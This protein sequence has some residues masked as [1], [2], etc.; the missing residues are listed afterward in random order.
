MS[1]DHNQ[2]QKPDTEDE[3]KLRHSYGCVKETDMIKL[4]RHPKKYAV[5]LSPFGREKRK[6][7]IFDLERY[8]KSRPQGKRTYY[9]KVLID[10]ITGTMY[11]F[12]SGE[13]LSST[14]LRIIS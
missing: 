12:M 9:Q 5:I 13:C 6:F 11:D 8:D 10:C 2:Y 4:K 3:P 7:S 1:G 14:R